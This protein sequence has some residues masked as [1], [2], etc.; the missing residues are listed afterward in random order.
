MAKV[1]ELHRRWSKEDAYSAAYEALDDEFRLPRVLI[2]TRS[3]AGLS[4]AELAARMKTSQS[5]IARIEGGQV[6]PSTAVLGRMAKAT[7]T[8]LR[9]AFEPADR[10]SNADVMGRLKAQPRRTPKP[11]AA[12]GSRAGRVSRT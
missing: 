6:C 1:K 2:D 9:I 12:K 7:G 4:Q 10:P 8:R 5:Y 3:K 11:S